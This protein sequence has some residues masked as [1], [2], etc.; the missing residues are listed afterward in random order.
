MRSDPP[1]VGCR[2]HRRISDFGFGFYLFV[3]I[4]LLVLCIECD[5]TF[6]SSGADH[7]FTFL[8]K[9]QVRFVT[10]L[11]FFQ[12]DNQLYT[13][14]IFYRLLQVKQM[15]ILHVITFQQP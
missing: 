3:V 8:S 12:A 13:L 5:L 1:L 2:P 6:L 9:H 15:I 7:I 14:Y 10:D 4:C 11:F